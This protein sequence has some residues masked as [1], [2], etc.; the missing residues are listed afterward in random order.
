MTCGT[1]IVKE[2]DETSARAAF[3]HGK[4]MTCGTAFF[5]EGDET[6]SQGTFSHGKAMTCGTA[7]PSLG[8]PC[9]FAPLSA[10]EKP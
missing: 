9:H 3:S 4:A 1:A 8:R 5:R 7:T 2:L 10:M 6:A